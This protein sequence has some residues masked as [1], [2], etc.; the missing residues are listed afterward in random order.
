MSIVVMVK[1][2][3]I[4]SAVC[5]VSRVRRGA[6]GDAPLICENECGWSERSKQRVD[7]GVMSTNSCD[8]YDAAHPDELCTTY[9]DT[10][11]R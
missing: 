3:A 5:V 6:F 4:L 1:R 2:G 7:A 11:T 10:T 9:V 8:S